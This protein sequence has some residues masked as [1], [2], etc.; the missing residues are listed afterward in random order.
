MSTGDLGKNP[1]SSIALLAR[2]YYHVDGLKRKGIIEK[3]DYVLTQIMPNYSK[4]MMSQYLDKV[5]SKAR[6]KPLDEIDAVYIT[7]GE[8]KKIDTLP[9]PRLRRLMF[10]MC[11]LAR[12]FDWKHDTNNHWINVDPWD[13]FDMAC[14]STTIDE[15]TKMYR[16]LID[17]D[18]IQYSKKVGNNNCRVLILD[19]SSPEVFIEDFRSMGHEYQ[20]YHGERYVRCERCGVLYKKAKG[21]KGTNYCK[22][23][24]EKLPMSM[25]RYNCIDCGK[26]VFV[27]SRNHKSS[28]CAECQAK[29]DLL[30]HKRYNDKRGNAITTNT[31]S[32]S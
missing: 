20:L 29:A 14:I 3:L 24:R 4:Q 10:T 19:D 2:Y 26:E 31:N 13:L 12:Y 25:R 23:C 11:A 6:E 21:S 18:Y 32:A 16:A 1:Y 27:I 22:A 5:A 28:R 9:T 8:I 17:A 15:Q 30:R 7:E